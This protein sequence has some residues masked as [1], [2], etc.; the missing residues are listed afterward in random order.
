MKMAVKITAKKDAGLFRRLIMLSVPTV[1]EEILSTLLQ[2]VDTAMVGQLGENATASVSVTTTIGWLVSSLSYAAGTAVLSLLS[3]CYGAGDKER[4]GKISKAAFYMTI[5]FGIVLGAISLILSP[6][7]PKWMGAQED[8]WHEASLYFSIISIPMIFRTGTALLGSAV[9]ATQNTRDPMVISIIGNAINII[10]NYILIYPAGMGV[11]GAAVASAAAFTAEG[12][13]IAVL[14]FKTDFL[15]WDR[16]VKV[17]PDIIGAIAKVGMPVVGTGVLSCMGYVVFAG[18]V[19]GMGTTV[20]A[21]HSIAVDAETLFYIPGYGLRTATATLIGASIGEKNIKKLIS[22]SRLSIALTVGLMLISGALLYILA[23]PLMRFFSSSGEVIRLGSE[24][25][26][27]I[28]F[29]EPFF[30]LMIVCEGVLYG[31]GSTRPVFIIETV[32]MWGVRIL[33]T[34]ITVKVLGLGLREVWYCMIADNIFKAVMLFIML[35]VKMKRVKR[36]Y[37]CANQQIEI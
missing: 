3:Q 13:M 32:S 1:I 18:L 2:Y 12:I 22:Y 33:L 15:R 27:L 6:F 14:Y 26:R 9:R 20:F 4:A 19:S 30:G 25:L 17:S 36:D 21:A 23:G 29:T 16:H 5:I 28:A 10:L 7:I 35:L 8:I 34:V 31:M 24:M 11:T 37:Y